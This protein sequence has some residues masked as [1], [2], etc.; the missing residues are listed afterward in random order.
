VVVSVTDQAFRARFPDFKGILAAR[1]KPVTVLD[2]A[3]L[4]VDPSMV[5]LAGSGTRVLEA[6]PR[7]ERPDRV[8][9]NGGAETVPALVDYLAQKGFR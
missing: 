7:A 6:Q 4:G 5:G 3:T 2:L 9:V 1:K 8:L